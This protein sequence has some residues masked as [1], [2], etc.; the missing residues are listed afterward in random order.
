MENVAALRRAGSKLWICAA[1]YAALIL[2]ISSI[3]GGSMPDSELVWS[4]DKIIHGVEYAVFAWLVAGA[5]RTGRS[6]RVAFAIAALGCAA[7]GAIDELYQSTVPGR[8]SSL[9][10]AMAD[11]AGAVIGAAVGC[12]W[13]EGKS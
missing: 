1:L 6:R 5:L 12:V 7:F 13:W 11:A 8:S 4:N 2:S 10:D 3:V 9:Y